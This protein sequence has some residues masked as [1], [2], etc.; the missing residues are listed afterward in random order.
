MTPFGVTGWSRTRSGDG[1]RSRRGPEKDELRRD[2]SFAR[3]R[4]SWARPGFEGD[5]DPAQASE[6]IQILPVLRGRDRLQGDRQQEQPA[7]D[8]GDT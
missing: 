8:G 5:S 4:P 3:D 1:T 2:P 7:H 6:V